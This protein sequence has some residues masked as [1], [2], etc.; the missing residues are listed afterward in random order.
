MGS[1]KIIN[2]KKCN[3]GHIEK[4][5]LNPGIQNTVL[6]QSNNSNNFVISYLSKIYDVTDNRLVGFRNVDTGEVVAKE[7]SPKIDTFN[8]T[9]GLYNIQRYVA[10]FNDGTESNISPVINL[11]TPSS[12]LVLKNGLIVTKSCGEAMP[13]TGFNN[14]LVDMETIS[15][16]DSLSKIKFTRLN[17]ENITLSKVLETDVEYSLEDINKITTTTPIVGQKSVF[18]GDFMFITD[19]GGESNSMSFS[20]TKTAC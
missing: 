20:F 17:F 5:Y 11:F 18:S 9:G 10:L 8:L 16:M 13:I 15:T 12:T 4:F 19:G 7:Y 2:K 14:S 1:L 3:E 6:H